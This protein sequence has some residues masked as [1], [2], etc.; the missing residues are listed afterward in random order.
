MRILL[1][2]LLLGQWVATWGQKRYDDKNLP[3][4]VIYA[5][6]VENRKGQKIKELDTLAIDD[7]LTIRQNGFLSMMH[8]FGFPI[9]INGDT[10]VKVKDIHVQFDLIK[11]AAK[12]GKYSNLRRPNIEYLFIPDGKL[13]L[14]NKS[15]ALPNNSSFC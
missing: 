11:N 4:Q 2:I 3:F 9:E 10:V 13:G 8:Y 7:I 15:S 1:I 5:E 14:N 6:N 12:K